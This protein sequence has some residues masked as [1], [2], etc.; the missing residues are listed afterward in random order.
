MTIRSPIRSPIRGAVQGVIDTGASLLA[1]IFDDTCSGTTAG[2][3]FPN[4]SPDVGNDWQAFAG[5]YDNLEDNGSGMGLQ[6]STT[7]GVNVAQVSISDFIAKVD[8]AIVTGTGING[9]GVYDIAAFAGSYG[10]TARF[11]PLTSEFVI[12]QIVNGSYSALH[13]DTY[14][15]PADPS[16]FNYYVVKNGVT[17][18][19]LDSGQNVIL[20]GDLTNAQAAAATLFSIITRRSGEGA[21]RWRVWDTTDINLIDE[22]T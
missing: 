17:V 5:G 19:L 11:Q 14:V 21:S 4:R 20:S 15:A 6:P 8:S 3:E 7:T 18:S 2:V 22:G 13:T 9:V 1:P 12:G 10:W 16:D